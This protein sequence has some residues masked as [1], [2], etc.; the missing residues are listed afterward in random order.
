VKRQA[1]G[2]A[3]K[4]ERL[5]T[6]YV[7]VLFAVLGV[8]AVLAVGVFTF[9][10]LNQREIS[11][12]GK[13]IGTLNTNQVALRKDMAEMRDLLRRQPTTAAA[14][15]VPRDIVLTVG[16][17]QFKGNA[18]ATLTLVEFTDYECPFCARHVKETFPQLEHDY[19][20]TGK[21][22]YVFRNFPLE[23]IH[24]KAFKA[25]EA[26]I[27]AGEQGKFWEM[28]DRLFAGQAALTPADIFNYAQAIGLKMGEF[29]GCFNVGL[30]TEQ[31]RKDIAEGQK[32]GVTATP[33]FFLGVTT[34]N[35]PT[36][37]VTKTIIGAKAYSAFKEEIDALLAAP[38][39][40]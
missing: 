7:P 34:P 27:C 19:I 3:A 36:L 33:V 18:N 2:D 4:A 10:R 39:P 21:I 13:E 40:S 6:G 22:K 26:A 9:G 17:A 29:Q 15:A 35:S 12:L 14:P 30:H 16:D 11:S 5:R 24:K 38:P 37:K 31:I 1:N 25:H 8:G 28:H 23:S 32:A 20:A